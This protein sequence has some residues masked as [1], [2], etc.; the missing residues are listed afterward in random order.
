MAPN[1]RKASCSGVMV[2]S[3]LCMYCLNETGLA[4]PL[5][6]LGNL[7]SLLLAPTSTNKMSP[8]WVSEDHLG[9]CFWFAFCFNVW[10]FRYISCIPHPQMKKQEDRIHAGLFLNTSRRRPLVS[11]CGR[12]RRWSRG[13]RFRS[14]PLLKAELG[15][16][17]SL[18]AHL[19]GRI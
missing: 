1:C 11:V 9:Q 19:P 2:Y 15:K 17:R 12:P 5:F 8:V 7:V 3:H 18:R 6:E 14:Q 4:E 16:L 13:A 10:S